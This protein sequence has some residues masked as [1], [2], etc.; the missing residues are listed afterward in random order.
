MDWSSPF[1]VYRINA[2]GKLEEVFHA[3]DLDK[4]KYWLTYIAK[5]GDV[6][7]KTPK[8]PSHSGKSPT[9]E[10]WS[11]K[12]LSGTPTA[13]EDAWNKIAKQKAPDV[14]FPQEQQ[15]HPHE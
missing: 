8:H 6:L 13:K 12:E 9:P 2:E 1:I 14:A 7:V 3:E 10:Y 11:H 15:K 4:A 5:P